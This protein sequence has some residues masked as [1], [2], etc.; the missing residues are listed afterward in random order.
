M[1]KESY[2]AYVGTYTNGKSLGIHIY[3][4]DVKEG[5]LHLRK[6][7]PIKNSPYLMLSRD[8][9]MLYSIADEGVEV[10]DILPDGD[11]KAV[12]RIDLDGMR[13]HQMTTDRTSKYLFVAG[14]HDGKVT[15]VHLHKDGRLGS[16]MDG[17]F[18]QR[19]G[20]IRERSWLPHVCCVRVTPDNNFLCAVDNSLNQVVLYAINR[21]KNKLEQIDIL[22]M[23]REVGPKSLRF[24]HDGRFAYLLCEITCMVR[25]YSYEVKNG[26]PVFTLLDEYDTISDKHD[27]YDAGASLAISKDGKYIVTSAA[28][29]NSIAIFEINQETGLLRRLLSLPIAG[30]YPKYTALFPDQKHV[31]VVNNGSNE[32]TTF[33]VDYEKGT[34]I[35]KGRPQKVDQPNCILFAKIEEGPSSFRN[36]T[37][38]EAEAEAAAQL[39]DE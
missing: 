11:L 1:A 14:Y 15:M 23:G 32:I 33:A 6:V 10:F 8:Q 16:Q 26:Y 19:Q 36:I 21:N 35:M 12:N 7:V 5:T 37:E 28:G 30:T 27:V 13:G 17:V 29:D 25:V 3:D 9:K 38:A 20:S 39:E 22:R 34:I 31:A 2:V 24:S 4:V 18:H